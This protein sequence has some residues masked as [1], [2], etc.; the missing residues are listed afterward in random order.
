[1]NHRQRVLLSLLLLGCL[2]LPAAAATPSFADKVAAIA[3]AETAE[4]A[5][6]D[7]ALARAGDQAEVLALQRCAAYVKLASRLALCEAQLDRA[8]PDPAVAAALADQI[9]ELSER[10]QIQET[11]LP[12]DYSFAPLAA[13]APEVPACDE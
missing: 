3:A 5:R 7:E 10:V 11:S 8:A 1:M 6:L 13:I 12:A 4:L 9:D 2:C